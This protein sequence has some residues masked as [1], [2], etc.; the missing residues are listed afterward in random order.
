MFVINTKHNSIE[1]KIMVASCPARKIG[2]STTLS[3]NKN[4]VRG[5]RNTWPGAYGSTCQDRAFSHLQFYLPPLA[6]LA[7]LAQDLHINDLIMLFSPHPYP[8]HLVKVN[9][10]M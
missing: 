2:T 5:G 7:S 6:S 3:S 10:N 9:P 8:S 4:S 1:Q